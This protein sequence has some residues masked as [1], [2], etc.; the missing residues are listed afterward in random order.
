MKYVSIEELYSIYSQHPIISKDSRNIPQGCL[1]FALKGEKFDG[2]KFAIESLKKG[3]AYAVVDDPK[4]AGSSNFLLVKDCLE[5]LQL[6]ANYHRKNLKIPIIGITG[7]NG[8]TT[9]KE[10]ISAVLNKKFK[11]LFTEGNYNNH[12]GVPLTI[13]KINESHEIAVI[14]MGANHQGEIEFLS[15]ICEPSHG[16]ITNIGKA[17]LEGFG[18][19]E[20]IKKGKS[21]LYRFLEKT[22]GVVFLNNDDEV[23]K[24][25]SRSE[26]PVMYGCSN[27]SYCIGSLAETHP[28]LKGEWSCQY[29][30]GEITPT[31][32]GEYNFYNILAS[33]CIG[34]YFGVESNRIDEAINSYESEMNRSQL[35]KKED[36]TIYLDA[37][38]ANP[39]SVQLAIENFERNVEGSKVIL[40]GDMFELG[41]ESKAEH[42]KVV[43]YLEKSE[44]FD[45]CILV[46]AHF[47][48]EKINNK[49][50]HFFKETAE[51]KKWFQATTK[52]NKSF[53]MK[54]S[55]GMKM[56]TILN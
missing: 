49:K 6:L 43:G 48:N 21:E 7:S 9:T 50:F 25:L 2:N 56:E 46:G 13:L 35:I 22:K 10:L 37:Y 53:L 29:Q 20:G 15:S 26:S 3:A 23:L 40:L 30:S 8:K 24:E 51:A 16:M 17:H 32:Y 11:T 45:S 18:G 42:K 36:H 4:V 44:M 39:S 31:L 55:R 38:N 19:V 12:I 1:Y 47:F 27:S 5:T 14:E 54:G 28:R 34:S 52:K 41:N 33:I